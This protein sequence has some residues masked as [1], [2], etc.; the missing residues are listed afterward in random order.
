MIYFLLLDVILILLRLNEG[1]TYNI[2]YQVPIWTFGI[3]FAVF[4]IIEIFRGNIKKYICK[5]N[6]SIVIFIII[7]FCG[8]IISDNYHIYILI[9]GLLCFVVCYNLNKCILY[10]DRKYIYV[11]WGIISF[12]YF[13]VALSSLHV[14]K[15]Y[16][17]ISRLLASQS[18]NMV[19]LANPTIKIDIVGGFGFCYALPFLILISVHLLLKK[20]YLFIL[21]LLIFSYTLWK[22]AYM[23]GVINCCLMLIVYL[24]IQII[25]KYLNRKTKMIIFTLIVTFC[26]LFIFNL[27]GINN[28]IKNT[29]FVPES[30]YLR[31]KEIEMF[32]K[33]GNI[34]V[35]S[36]LQLRLQVYITSINGII[37]N[38]GM[39]DFTNILSG[40]HSTILDTIS[41]F[42]LFSL[43]FFYY[44]YISI[45]N[46]FKFMS[47]EK[48][49]YYST[50]FYFS[51]TALLNP[52]ILP[53][54]AVCLYLIMP[55]GLK[56]YS[57][58]HI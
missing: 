49:I 23:I 12:D 2:F 35:G 43:P 5:E 28:F 55:L 56:L 19:R 7:A 6:I 10:L 39:F 42:G 30:Y 29:D 20:K 46:I 45:K 17:E 24:Y 52:I 33:S 58:I 15:I 25:K 22:S 27:S 57:E 11:I 31:L 44:I 26:V 8:Y 14:Y 37:K 32:L 50:L 36:D 4:C 53:Q 38:K 13:W 21:P 54:I 47:G 41:I 48:A 18:L 9:N 40:G 51:V 3:L 34:V 16:P 1:I